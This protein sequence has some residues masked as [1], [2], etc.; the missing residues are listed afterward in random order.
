MQIL[1]NPFHF[2]IKVVKMLFLIVLTLTA[3]FVCGVFSVDTDRVTMT[4][5]DSLTLETGIKTIH[6]EDIKWY[7]D[8]SRIAQINGDQSFICTDVHC[9][10]GTERFRNRLKLDHQTGSLTITDTRTT[11][12]G[13]YKLQMINNS[14]IGERI[15]SVAVVDVPATERDEMLRKSVMEGES[16]TL[17]PGL[18]KNPNDVMTWYFNDTLVAEIT[19]DQSQICTDDECKERFRDRLELDLQ[20]GSLTIMNIKSTDSGLYKLQIIIS[21]RRR[22]RSISITSWKTFILTVFDF[23]LPSAAVAG[24]CL[25]SAARCCCSCCD[26]LWQ[27]SNKKE[28]QQEVLQ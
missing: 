2:S 20:T 10:T 16:V 12:S 8:N 21:T 5:G 24:I 17:D 14:S 25:C 9:N 13:L 26:L 15:F 27:A 7:Y 4:E 1:F 23:A 3:F 6:L 28:R 19:G 22:R 11:D 18:K